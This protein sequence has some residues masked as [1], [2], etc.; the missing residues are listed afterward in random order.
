MSSR[1]KVRKTNGRGNEGHPSWRAAAFLPL[2]LGMSVPSSTRAGI[3]T[4]D[5]GPA[6]VALAISVSETR[7]A[8]LLHIHASR[9]A[10]SAASPE[11]PQT[12][13]DDG[14]ACTIDTC[15]PSSGCQHAP[16]P[17]CLSVQKVTMRAQSGAGGNGKVRATGSFV[18]PP[19]VSGTPPVKVEVK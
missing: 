17:T 12:S 5:P 1:G 13:C 9:D 7:D 18:V 19:D 11:P 14:D 8:I 16:S 10:L 4:A 3:A 2:V 6:P 15:D